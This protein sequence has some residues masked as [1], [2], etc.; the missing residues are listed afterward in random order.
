MSQEPDKFIKGIIDI[1]NFLLHG[2]G[3]LYLILV[4]CSLSGLGLL[5][6]EAFDWLGLARWQLQTL[7]SRLFAITIV[8]LIAR[9]LSWINIDG[10]IGDWIQNWRAERK[11]RATIHRLSQEDLEILCQFIRRNSNFLELDPASPAVRSLCDKRLI[12]RSHEH[13]PGT[14]PSFGGGFERREV[15]EIAGWAR[16]RLSGKCVAS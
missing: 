6:P 1:V 2:R 11:K 3:T 9:F 10:L 7:F 4:L 8:I 12:H 15:F 14:F 5:F 13:L 16:K